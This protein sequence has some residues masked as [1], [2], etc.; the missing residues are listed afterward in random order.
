MKRKLIHNLVRLLM[1]ALIVLWL[2][3]DLPALATGSIKE[4]AQRLFQAEQLIDPLID[5]E[6]AA[7]EIVRTM[8]AVKQ[9][10]PA[11][12]DIETEGSMIRTSNAWL[13]T[14]ADL[15]I[16]NAYGD[17]EQ[18]RSML[19]EMAD[20][21]LILEQRVTASTENLTAADQRAALE[22]IL[23]RTE[24]LP[25]EKK[26]SVVKKWGRK[27]WDQLTNLLAKL[28]GNRNPTVG[29]SGT[30]SVSAVRLIVTLILLAAASFG[31]VKLLKRLSRRRKKDDDE[32]REVLG[33]ELPEDMT[34]ADLLKNARQLAGNGDF[35]SAIR[36][37][38]IA[39]LCELEQRGK[40]RLHR[41]KTNRD[42]LDE[43][44]PEASLYTTFSVMTGAFEHVWYGQEQAT[45][46]EFNEFLTLYQETVG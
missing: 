27:L 8:N 16:K 2:G 35:R 42:Y 6:P 10:I 45:E 30:G 17:E 21:L 39:L 24:Y 1:A 36:R 12:E 22:K 3:A 15:V 34:A 5:S 4:Y 33:E 14:A 26:D 44:K 20:K 43:L 38:Y 13:H 28:F 29:D 7:A 41:A 23:A 37:S 31:L 11:E 25:E 40:V 32:I 46:T 18:V 9:L 19:I